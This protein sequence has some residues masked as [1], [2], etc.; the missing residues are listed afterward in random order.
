[1]PTLT[2]L[3]DFNGT[4]GAFPYDALTADAAGD[5]F[6]TTEQ[7]G[8]DDAGTVFEIV[9]TANGYA[10]TPTTLASFNGTNGQYP[11]AGLIADAA[12]DLFG[13]I[14]D[15][16]ANGDGEVFE[17]AKTGGSYASTPTILASFNGPNGYY[18]GAGLIADAAGDLF[19]TT[20][21]GGANGANNDGTVFEIAKTGSGYA[22][23]PATLVSFNG[24][25]G[26]EPEADLIADAAGDLFGTTV[27]GGADGD[28][29]VFEIARTGGG[30]ASTPATLASFNG[31]N[32]EYP[33]DALTADAAGDLFGTTASGGT[34]NVGTV[35]EIAKTGGGYA[36][37]RPRWRASTAPTGQTQTA[38]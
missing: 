5:L 12:G 31:T 11:Q 17:I 3:V 22:G 28:G 36:G 33:Y 37:T 14:F 18:L 9:K 29:T 16:G 30:Y 20:E 8:A 21:F 26:R 32:G 10:S 2:T 7:G 35:F 27:L 19:G 1:M 24:A 23:T 25:N 6:G 38:V 15:G 4:N 13:T 34:N